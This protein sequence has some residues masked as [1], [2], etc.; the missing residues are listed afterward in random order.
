M[1]P[2]TNSTQTP[3]TPK[4]LHE[5]RFSERASLRV[6][7]VSAILPAHLY[8]YAAAGRHLWTP[9]E[10]L[11]VLAGTLSL[12]ILCVTRAA[13][14]H[15]RAARNIRLSRATERFGM[16]WNIIVLLTASMML[17]LSFAEPMLAGISGELMKA[18]P[19]SPLF[20]FKIS[21]VL[22]SLFCAYGIFEA[23]TI[24]TVYITVKTEKDIGGDIRIVQLTDLHVNPGLTPS[25]LARTVDAALEA[26]P[27]IIVITGDII[28]G[29]AGDERGVFESYAPYAE[30]LAELALYAPRLGV[31]AI[32]GNHD[33]FDGLENTEAFLKAAGIRLMRSEKADLGDIV[34]LGADD[35][36]HLNTSESDPSLSVSEALVASLSDDEKERFVLLLRHRP[37]IEPS[38][39]GQFDLQLSGHTHGGQLF[40]LPSSRHR[41]PGHTRGTVSLGEGSELYV[42]NGAGFVGPPMR[43]LAPAEVAVI[44]VK[45]DSSQ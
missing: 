5:K 2:N 43:I 33:Y 38:T 26:E 31:W 8:L 34:L 36:D 19:Y 7:A 44:D 37:V 35:P 16:L 21:L 13:Q 17:V 39:V 29:E 40:T 22:S 30:K 3:K 32:P 10:A 25:H 42:S 4:N 20:L 14:V 27:D 41:I 24:R 18:L 11:W 28:D 45:K 6:L 15:S 12:V 1:T 23:R 9:F